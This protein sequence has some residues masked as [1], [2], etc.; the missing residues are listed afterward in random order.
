MNSNVQSIILAAGKGTRMKS[1]LPK[2]LNQLANKALL[3]HVIETAE[4]ISSKIAVVVGHQAELV[5]SYCKDYPTFEQKEQLGTGHAVQQV[6]SEIEDTSLALILY[7][8]VPLIEASTLQALIDN[9]KNGLSILTVKLANPDGYGRIIRENGNVVAIVEQ[10]DATDDQKQVDEV[11]TGILCVEGKRLKNYLAQLSNNNAQ[12]EY[13]LTDIIAMH[14]N[15]GNKADTYICT[16]EFE[17]QGVNDKWQLAVLERDFQLKQAKQLCLQ[18]ANII[19][20]NRID[21]RG[22]VDI[23]ID[24]RIDVNVVFEG[25]VI[26][27]NNVSIGPNC[28]VKNSVIGDGA[29]LKENTSVD[30]CTIGKNCSVGPFTRIR[31]RADIRDEVKIGNFVEVKKSVIG[32]GSKVSHLSYIGDTLMGENVNIGAGTITCNYDGVNKFITNIED[33][34]FV[35]SASQL[36]APVTLGKGST[37]GAGSAITKD[38]AD[39]ELVLTRSAQRVVKN[40]KRPVKK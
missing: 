40:W 2:V 27:G 32:K 34:V 16:D 12:K 31:P 14:V 6:L 8:D 23:G 35:G 20:P 26:L 22:T 15:A 36:V 38:V 11:N 10:K 37:V 13:Y 4:S 33:D 18:G 9:T 24:V 17:V 28:V 30:Q 1:G 19:D 7:G 25:N 39:N 5:A 21:I 3:S 29:E